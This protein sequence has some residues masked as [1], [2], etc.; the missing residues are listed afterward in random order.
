MNV[1]RPFSVLWPKLTQ[2]SRGKITG[3][4]SYGLIQPAVQW[5]REAVGK[6]RA[7]A[8]VKGCQVCIPNYVYVRTQCNICV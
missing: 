6:D 2:A 8:V 3:G 4:D 5:T 7:E 1:S